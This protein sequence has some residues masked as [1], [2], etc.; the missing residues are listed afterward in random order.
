MRPVFIL[1]IWSTSFHA[2]SQSCDTGTL[3]PRVKANLERIGDLKPKLNKISI[4]Q[5]KQDNLDNDEL[6]PAADVVLVKTSADSIP[7]YVFNAS[8]DKN[9]PVILYF[10]PGGFVTPFLPFMKYDCWKMS[11]DHHAIVV[12]V[13]YR[14]A[15]EHKFP[16]AVNDAYTSFQWL[17]THGHIYGGNV[18]QLIVAGMSAGAN[19]SAVVSQRAKQ[20]GLGTKI[21]LQILNCPSV[22][23]VHH[24]VNYPSYRKY[25][26][27]YFQ[28]REFMVFAQN[29]YGNEND[30]NNPD[31]SPL[32]AESFQGLPPTVMF[33][34]EFDVLKDEE[35]A[36][37]KRLQE[38]GVKVWH[39]CF[40]G[41]IHC[42]VG[43]PA[44]AKEFDILN[45]II[46]G[47]MAAVLGK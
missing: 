5:V 37:L 47:A 35:M 8:H 10:H 1:L 3:D 28:T 6:Y 43:L 46:S 11:K 32:L 16:T 29:T 9:L 4:E 26:S 15:P 20:N 23:N 33:T 13:D 34:A 42:L 18:D 45:D 21:K 12:A 31:F 19:L 17:L 7:V 44:E 40:A 22:D 30:F 25:A 38:A 24:Q 36:Y 41:Q 39:H 27:G 14:I 2:M